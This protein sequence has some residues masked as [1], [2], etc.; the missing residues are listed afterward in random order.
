YEIKDNGRTITVPPNKVDELR[1]ALATDGFMPSGTTG[2]EL[3]DKSVLGMSDFLQRQNRNRAVEG[4]LA[5]TLMSLNE[6]SAARV[7]LTLPE[8]T[9]F[10]A[11]QIEP[12]ASVAIALKPGITMSNER[13]A[14]VRTFVAGAIGSLDPDKVTIIDQNMNLLTGPSTTQPGRLL[15]TQE[16]ARRNYETQR[17]ADI[18][19]LLERAYGVGKVAVSF[20]CQ[21]NFDQVESESL[22]YEPLSGSNTGVL[23]SS[24]FTETSMEGQG[25]GFGGGIPGTESNI[26]SYPGAGTQPYKSDTFTETK[27]YEISQVHETRI[28]APGKVESSSV[29]VL[30]DSSARSD[31]PTSEIA[32]VENLIIAAAGL[33]KATGD[34]I[35]IS[36]MPFDT[37]LQ[38]EMEAQRAA[39]ASREMWDFLIK[40]GVIL[41]V[42]VIFWVV[43]KNFLKPVELAPVGPQMMTEEEER[44]I[45]LP[46]ADPEVIEK[47]RMREE[48]EKL[49]KEDPASA[50]KVVKTWLRE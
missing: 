48:I 9:P 33:N 23:R 42:L 34:V 21:M 38:E 19:A 41:F 49:I 17:A 40:L 32:Q 5:R 45:E 20:S 4:E 3:F 37:S 36:F 11:D 2:Y 27:N 35:T 7:H 13:V 8:P 14:A 26:P 46:S 6:V 1:L 22:K 12:M 29:G 43:L 44:E 30:I 25:T 10:I 47:L 16:E 24:E 18:R 28:E 15:P 50:A 31:V 39:F